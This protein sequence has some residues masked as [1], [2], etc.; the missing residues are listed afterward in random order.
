MKILIALV[1]II[2]SA[3]ATAQEKIT[4]L[5]ES[6]FTRVIIDGATTGTAYRA[7]GVGY[8]NQLTTA[9]SPRHVIRLVGLTKP[10]S[11]DT[12]ITVRRGARILFRQTYALPSLDDALGKPGFYDEF[13]GSLNR[14]AE[15]WTTGERA[16]ILA[17][18]ESALLRQLR[19]EKQAER[20]FVDE[21]AAELLADEN[22]LGR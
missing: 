14:S 8:D 12:T 17:D 21:Q 11:E 10:G 1:L 19:L 7:F 15:N 22:A 16:A 5:P 3:T 20:E 4:V 13:R 6:G 2:V 18:F 9:T